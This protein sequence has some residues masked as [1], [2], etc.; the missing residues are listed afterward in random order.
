M[1]NA[2]SKKLL[3]KLYVKEGKSTYTIANLLGYS[4]STIQ[5]RCKKYGIKLRPSQKGKLKGIHRGTIYKLYVS[6]KKSI[7]KIARLLN[8]S[9]SS[10][11]YRCKKYG[12]KLRP[13][14]KEIP[15]LNR[16]ILYR[17]YVKEGRSINKIAE[18]FAC[19]HSVIESRCIQNGIEL[20]APKRI[21]GL[22]KAL[23]YKLYVQEEKTVRAIAKIIGCSREPIR[24]KCKEF[25]VPLRRPGN[26]EL[27]EI[28]EPV[29]RQLYI[30]EGKGVTEI[31]KQCGCVPS[32]I[33]QRIKRF[34]LKDELRQR[35]R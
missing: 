34:G 35:G 18:K 2:I 28:N 5:Y 31:A 19:S 12:I 21:K 14:K 9:P 25:G 16:S 20:R 4:H 30:N 15:G 26:R 27:V 22:T 17:L 23:L 24:I 10:I 33:S 29:L 8:C 7:H 13:R 1:T 3:Q 32:T 11:L 6:D